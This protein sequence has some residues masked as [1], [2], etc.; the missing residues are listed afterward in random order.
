MEIKV[1][2]IYYLIDFNSAKISKIKIQEIKKDISLGKD[3]YDRIIFNY[4]SYALFRETLTNKL[5]SNINLESEMYPKQM[6][7]F[8]NSNKTFLIFSDVKIAQKTLINFVLP[9]RL[10]QKKE[11]AD[12][13][14]KEYQKIIS[15]V[16]EIETSIQDNKENFDKKCNSLEKKFV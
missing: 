9:T 10:E 11:E 7:V 5:I 8:R 14:I 1:G 6:F 15:K 4:N 2:N 3:V 12:K 13:L 16:E